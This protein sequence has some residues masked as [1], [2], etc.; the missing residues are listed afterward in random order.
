M[1]LLNKKE[2]EEPQ[3]SEEFGYTSKY[4]SD[5]LELI[6][7]QQQNIVQVSEE[8]EKAFSQI[9][10]IKKILKIVKKLDQVVMKK[11]IGD[12]RKK[13]S[14]MINLMEDIKK[15]LQEKRYE[16]IDKLMLKVHNESQAKISLSREE[17]RQLRELMEDLSELYKESAGLCRLYTVVYEHIK[18]IYETCQKE[19]RI[20]SQEELELS[21]A[22]S[23]KKD[24]H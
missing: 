14:R 13:S 11:T 10:K 24:I 1:L 12:K 20:E 6:H 17:L 19:L 22:S 3:G 4:V 23:Y 15:N 16:D 7:D 21:T 8:L 18:Q 9:A 5:E 2:G